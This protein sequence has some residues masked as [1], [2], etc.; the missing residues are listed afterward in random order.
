MSDTPCKSILFFVVAPL[1]F[2]PVSIDREGVPVI[3]APATPVKV[4][5]V[6]EGGKVIPFQDIFVMNPSLSARAD[7]T[8]RLGAW[9]EE[10]LEFVR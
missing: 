3:S 2:A 9:P 10:P 5:P 4:R 8:E 6:A 1:C 7:Q